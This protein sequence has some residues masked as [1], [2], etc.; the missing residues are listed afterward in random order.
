MVKVVGT[1]VGVVWGV[2]SEPVLDLSY[3]DL[4]LEWPYSGGGL[5]KGP[6]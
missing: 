5:D 1:I 4:P 3:N 2:H 6:L